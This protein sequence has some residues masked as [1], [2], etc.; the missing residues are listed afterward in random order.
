MLVS[1][2]RNVGRASRCPGVRTGIVSP[3]GVQNARI[4]SSTP[5]NDLASGPH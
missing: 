1:G 4:I 3:A 2:I 5:D